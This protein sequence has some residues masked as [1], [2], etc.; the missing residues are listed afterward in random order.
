MYMYK[1]CPP[2]IRDPPKSTVVASYREPNRGPATNTSRFSEETA[3]IQI[4]RYSSVFGVAWRGLGARTV[5]GGL[6]VDWAGNR[7]G[8]S[9]SEPPTRIQRPGSV[10][11]IRI[12]G[13]IPL[14]P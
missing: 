8:G 1:R 11:V 2:P 4:F 6:P 3:K 13:Y 10:I 5:I 9:K 14:D 7:R 12:Y